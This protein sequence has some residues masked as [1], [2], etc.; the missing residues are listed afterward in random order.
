MRWVVA[1]LVLALVPVPAA[2]ASAT[3]TDAV[4]FVAAGAR[5]AAAARSPVARSE[6]ADVAVATFAARQTRERANGRA[7]SWI[8]PSSPRA[9]RA[10]LYLLHCSLLR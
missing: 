10:G 2:A 5:G 9:R 7:P 1:A 6:G 3:A 4:V 8:V